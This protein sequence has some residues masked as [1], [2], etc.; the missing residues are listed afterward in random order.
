MVAYAPDG[1]VSILLDRMAATVQA[2]AMMALR[3][4]TRVRRTRVRWVL[5]A[6]AFVM[7]LATSLLYLHYFDQRHEL[8]HNDLIGRQFAVRAALHGEDPYTPEMT[9]EI[10][11]VAGHDPG[12]GF[13][14]PILLGVLLVP[15]AY[16]PWPALRLG[17]V[18]A[19][20]PALFLSFRL[21]VPLLSLRVTRAG[22][23]A[24]AL[25]CLCSWPVVYGLRLQQ[26]TLLIAVLVF[27]ACWLLHREQELA[28]GI[29]L[30]LSTFKPQ[31]VLP[32]LL[33][34][35]LWSVARRRW[36]LPVS[37]A[38]TE[39]VYLFCGERLAPGWFP[40]WLA[41]LHRYH[42]LATCLPLQLIFGHWLG[43]L[44]T[45]AVVALGLWRL[46]TLRRAGPGMAE[47]GQAIALALAITVCIT[48]IIWAM[49]YNQVVLVPAAMLMAI[50]RRPAGRGI[51]VIVF[52]ITQFFLIWTFASVVVGALG[53][54]LYPS[55]VWIDLPFLNHLLA[56]ALVLALVWG[57][58]RG[59]RDRTM[60][61]E[62]AAGMV[63]V[64]GS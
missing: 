33:W 63:G 45:C 29:L 52:R 27:P 12:Q 41:T 7:L 14:Y 20:I 40:Q 21:C 61:V 46:W 15:V 53:N 28:P 9:R 2:Q 37:F 34:L 10:Q 17:F 51:R 13:D 30:A 6:A 5:I 60:E 16:V 43:L 39:A 4:L 3:S 32:L 47:F 18:L 1:G 49:I 54:M 57:M 19:L 56:P 31:L 11:A 48:P 26:P 55:I 24:I 38:I 42:T 23:S 44:F 25:F 58:V 35:L 22:A 36:V 8:I 59:D 62:R 50:S 64:T